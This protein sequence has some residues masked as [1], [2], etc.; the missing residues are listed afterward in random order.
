MKLL[1]KAFKFID[2]NVDGALVEVDQFLKDDESLESALGIC[3]YVNGKRDDC[4]R[5]AVY[6]DEN[7]NKPIIRFVYR[8]FPISTKLVVSLEYF[9]ETDSIA[10]RIKNTWKA[11]LIYVHEGKYCSDEK[12]CLNKYVKSKLV[13]PEFIDDQLSVEEM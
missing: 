3:L 13:D 12:V 4:E 2:K 6:F 1:K 7:K 9:K 10:E 8:A 5:F 11:F